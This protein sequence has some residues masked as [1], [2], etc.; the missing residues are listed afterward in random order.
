M[1]P[2][3]EIKEAAAGRWAE[4][5][6]RLTPLPPDALAKR[7]DDHPCPLCN[8]RSV[9]WPAEDAQ[10]SGR[11]ACR[12]CTDNKPTGDG[13]ATVAAFAGLSQGDA[14]KAVAEFLG[15]SPRSSDKPPEIDIIAEVCKQ[16]RMPVEAFLQFGAIAEKRGREKRPVARV[17]V[18][19]ETGEPHSHFD[20]AANHKGWFARGVGMA[21]MFLPGRKPTAG[22]TWYLVEGCKDAAALVGLGFNAAGMPTSYLAAKYARLFSGCHIV[23]VPDLDTAGQLGAQKTGGHLKGIAASVRVARLPGEIVSRG[24][25]DVRDA[26][27]RPDGERLVREAID[28]AASWMPADGEHDP[29]DGR[30]EVT[31]TLNYGWA[32]DQV[33]EYLGK[34]GWE[35]PWLPAKKR[36]RLKLYQRG[37]ALVHVVTE[38]EPTE[39]SGGITTP[40]GTARIRPLPLGQLPLRIADA[41]QLVVE[42]EKEGE[43]E[44]AATPPPRWLLDGVYTRGDYGRDVRRLDGIISAPT[45]RAD[46]TVLQSAGYD[47]KTGLLYVPNGTFPKVPERPT[48]E[49]ARSAAAELLEVV[50]DF[51]F[52]DDADRSAW[53]AMVLTKIGRTAITGCCPLFAGTATT[54]ASGKSLLVDGASLIA[55]GRPAARKPYAAE[56]DEMRKAITATAMEALPAVLLDNV[57]RTLG[58]ASLDAALTALTW[59]DRVLGAS[60]TTGELPLR[61]I[62]SATGNNLRFGSDLA[63]RVLPIRLEPSVENPEERTDFEHSDL[64]GWVREN[65][66]RLAIAALTILRAYFVAGKPE[67]PRGVWGSFETWSALIRGAIVWAGLADPLAT[68]ETAKADDT[69]GAIVR[70]LIGGLLEVDEHGDGLTVREIITALTAQGNED[71]FP[72]M[73]EAVSEVATHRG[74]IDQRRLGYALRKYKGRVA[75]GWRITGD[76]N[77]TGVI[78]WRSEKASAGDAGDAGDTFTDPYAGRLCVSHTDTHIHDSDTHTFA[79]GQ[80]VEPSPACP[81][82]PADSTTNAATPTKHPCPRCGAKLVRKP[83][84]PVIG[85]YVNLDCLT[86]GCDHVK[87]VKV[88]EAAT[89]VQSAG[90]DQGVMF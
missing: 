75:G 18:Y 82:S 11:V 71:R 43:L 10:Q 6:P 89:P 32:A 65:R 68:R 27:R 67:Q 8:G 16:K 53:L 37:G 54:R 14:A 3:N 7:A 13:I 36:E 63:R 49:D 50:K 29:Q 77:R 66:P 5:L 26:L 34:L 76:A 69:S 4:I 42:V 20:F 61:T 48:L 38:D 24:G 47:K 22:E 52:V 31:L 84:T 19:D 45:L 60:K 62:W 28:A 90:D 85:G 87:A 59:S 9:L 39:L 21:G 86:P 55:Y 46:G 15:L 78:A 74:A 17:P 30:P 25:D 57:D 51:P 44:K 35:T 33:T 58:G 70:G 88:V 72:A 81:A 40:A 2:F 23:L 1:I 56:D 83:E 41:V 79:S 80:P 12:N 64:L 73:R